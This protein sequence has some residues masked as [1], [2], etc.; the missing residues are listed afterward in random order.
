MATVTTRACRRSHLPTPGACS[1]M[2]GQAPIARLLTA[3]RLV[4]LFAGVLPQVGASEEH[5]PLNLAAE[6]VVL[7]AAP[8][9]HVSRFAVMSS[10][11][12]PPRGP[13]RPR[14][15]TTACDRRLLPLRR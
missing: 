6:A 12:R 9:R 2:S 14:A 13:A 11:P 7:P 15:G 3:R 8:A 10:R 5:P 4:S 1:D